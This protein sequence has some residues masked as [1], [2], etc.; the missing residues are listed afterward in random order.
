MAEKRETKMKN[1]IFLAYY[2]HHRIVRVEEGQEASVE[3]EK[4][5]M[6]IDNRTKAT[7]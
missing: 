4:K 6:A 5:K 1:Q 2:H 3:A 7:E